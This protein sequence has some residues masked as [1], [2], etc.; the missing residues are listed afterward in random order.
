MTTARSTAPAISGFLTPQRFPDFSGRATL[1]P[2]AI[3]GNPMTTYCSLVPS[4]SSC[5]TREPRIRLSPVG[6][7]VGKA[8]A[9]LAR[10][11]LFSLL[12]GAGLAIAQ[13]PFT[14]TPIAIPGTWEA[15]NFDL[16]GEGVAYHDNT[17]GNAGGQYRLSEDVDI[18]VSTDSAGGAYVV[19]S[20][21]T[22]EWLAY[23]INVAASAQYD[24]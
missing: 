11:A 15:E 3:E 19:G 13:T 9:C 5:S 8:A 2:R 12:A 1:G 6:A 4:E 17:P 7:T 10:A 21:E 24:I 22:G 23:T 16:G 14:G 20:F 18:I